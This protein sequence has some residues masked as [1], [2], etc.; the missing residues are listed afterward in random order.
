MILHHTI[1]QYLVYLR[2]LGLPSKQFH[3]YQQALWDIETFYGPDTPL[4]DFDD[5]LVLD[6]ARVNDPFETDPIKVTRGTVFC[7]FTEWLMVNHLIPA[8]AKEM[9][10]DEKS[11]WEPF[12]HIDSNNLL[13]FS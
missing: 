3:S 11:S 4:K 13:H 2:A 5:A 9:Q 12:P 8:W 1:M 7:D 6:Y 10:V